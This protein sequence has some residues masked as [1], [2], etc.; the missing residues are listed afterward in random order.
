MFPLLFLGA[1]ACSGL[2]GLIYEVSWT[3]LLTLEMGRGIA[4]S[5]TVLAAFMGGL[6]LGAALAGRR[7]SAMT[8]RQALQAYAGL[9]LAVAVLA[10]ALPFELRALSPLFASAY[11]N[12]SAGVAFGFVRFGVSL[13]LLLLPAMALGATFPVAVRWFAHGTGRGSRRAGQLYAANTIGAAIGALL[14]GFVLVP[15]VG[16]MGTLLVGVGTSLIAMAV[17]VALS[18][19]ANEPATADREAQLS[20]VQEPRPRKPSQKGRPASEKVRLRDE[21]EVAR[22]V[23]AAALLAITGAATLVAEVAWTRVFALLVGPSTYAFAATVAAFIGGL[24][25]GATTGTAIGARTRRPALAIGLLLG[26]A[27]IG[28]AWASTAA[29]TSLPHRVV[30][31]FA[32]SPDISI[33]GHAITLSLIVLPMAFA[34]GAAFPLSLQLAGGADAPPRTIGSV[35]AINTLAAVAGSL[36]AGFFLI[37]LLGLEQT[38]TVVSALLAAGAL[39]AAWFGAARAGR[40]AAL[41]PVAIGLLLMLTGEPWDRALLAS[42]SYKYASAVAPGLDVET[43]LKSGTLIYYRDGA[44]S[45]VSVKRLTGALS[46]AI[47]GKVDASTAGDMLTQKLLAHLP[48]LLHGSAREICIIGLGSGVTLASALTH[49]VEAVDVLEISRWRWSKRPGSSRRRA[50]GRRSTTRARIW[51][52]PTAGHI[53]RS[54]PASTT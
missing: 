19:P 36:A 52:L 30:A 18:L 12:G 39:L 1:Y 46:L 23:L 4:A 21:V 2:A 15:L 45:T 32:S 37:P 28:S 16:V 5:S 44:T 49:P 20:P 26:A 47:D 27:T 31:D 54:R 14:S 51:W 50:A 48:M 53:W 40:L 33:V 11:Q 8:P 9:E 43:A 34:I 10:I 35:Y 42:G 3:R 7:A 25:L 22:P 13:L 6:A 17:A 24:A 41:V 29:G 38:L